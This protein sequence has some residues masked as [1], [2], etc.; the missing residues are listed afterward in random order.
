LL[1][2]SIGHSL[3]DVGYEYFFSFLYLFLGYHRHI[4]IICGRRKERL[5][6]IL[7]EKK[8]DEKEKRMFAYELDVSNRKSCEEFVKTVL[9][10]HPDV[11]SLVNNA[12]IQKELRFDNPSKFNEDDWD[13]EISINIQGLIRLTHLFLPHFLENPHGMI[14]NVTSGLALTPMANVPVYCACKAFVHSYSR[15]L[16]QQLKNT[17]VRVVEVLPPAVDTEINPHF[18]A[19]VGESLKKFLM[20]LKEYNDDMMKKF[21]EGHLEFGVGTS[22][23]RLKEV[24]EDD[25]KRFDMMNNRF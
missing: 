21:K 3:V 5:D 22:D 19:K 12:G 2:V 4:V 6:E 8:Q 23:T 20:P 10:D 7:A 17:N 25:F 14:M 15:S 16:R 1:S 9:S 13:E 24:Q 11:D 18:R